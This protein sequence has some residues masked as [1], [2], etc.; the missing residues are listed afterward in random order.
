VIKRKKNKKLYDYYKNYP[1]DKFELW[2]KIHNR[3]FEFIRTVG[4]IVSGIGG[5][6]AILRIFGVI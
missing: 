3:K 4:N 2:C 5:M 6:L 1:R